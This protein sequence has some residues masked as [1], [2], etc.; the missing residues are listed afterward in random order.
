MSKFT[1]SQV[2][3]LGKTQV[4]HLS[5]KY[6]SMSPKD[7]YKDGSYG[8]PKGIRVPGFVFYVFYLVAYTREAR[9][10]K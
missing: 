4:F 10:N 2:H 1:L 9:R 8:K 5:R 3:K 6:M 7:K